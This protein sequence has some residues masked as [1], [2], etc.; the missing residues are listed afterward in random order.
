MHQLEMRD[1]LLL[2][3]IVDRLIYGSETHFDHADA[4]TALSLVPIEPRQPW[5]GIKAAGTGGTKGSQGYA[6]GVGNARFDEKRQFS[7][8]SDART[9]VRAGQWKLRRL[10]GRFGRETLEIEQVMT[11]EFEGGRAARIEYRLQE[12]LGMLVRAPK[13]LSLP[14]GWSPKAG[15]WWA[16]FSFDAFVPWKQVE[17][18]SAMRSDPYEFPTQGDR[19]GTQS[20]VGAR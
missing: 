14:I 15:F 1:R 4:V 13:S 16:T 9:G 19:S 8:D 18:S 17:K 10:T 3:A 5:L 2:A 7:F 12:P 11:D 20:F 6:A